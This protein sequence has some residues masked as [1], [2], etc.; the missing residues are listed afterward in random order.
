MQ[1]NTKL[2]LAL[3]ISA[4]LIAACDPVDAPLTGPPTA[5]ALS[6]MPT[7]P[8]GYPADDWVYLPASLDPDYRKYECT[9]GLGNGV[10]RNADSACQ[11]K[12][13][14]KSEIY[15]EQVRNL[16]TLGT[17]AS[18]PCGGGPADFDG[19]RLCSHAWPDPTT[20]WGVPGG[21]GCVLVHPTWRCT[22]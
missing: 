1:S 17:P 20:P 6:T 19:I 16:H 9:F 7:N 8:E 13:W 18:A 10:S 11:E 3:G 15:R 2:A 22:A 14:G 21:Q 4:V 12:Q 5:L